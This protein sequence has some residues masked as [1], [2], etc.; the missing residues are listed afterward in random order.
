MD[1]I[2]A[3]QNVAANSCAVRAVA[4]EEV[5]GDPP[6][7]SWVKEQSGQ[8]RMDARFASRDRAVVDHRLQPAAVDP[9]LRVFEAGIGTAWLARYLLPDTV[10]IEEFVGPNP[11]LVEFREQ[12]QLR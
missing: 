1:A 5:T 4:A 3:D 7:S 6:P 10:Q 8:P 2:G 11:G 9:E 12:P